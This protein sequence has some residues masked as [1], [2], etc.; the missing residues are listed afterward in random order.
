MKV[1]DYVT[2]KKYNHDIIFKIT[3]I[4]DG[5]AYLSGEMY[6]LAADASLDDLVLANKKD[7]NEEIEINLVQ[8]NNLIK[9]KI[10]HIDGDKTYLRKCMDFYKENLTPVIGCYLQ[11]DKMKDNIT[12]LLKKHCPDILIITGHDS[13]SFKRADDE[14]D[15]T[16]TLIILSMLLSKLDYINQIKMP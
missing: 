2:R 14:N 12:L 16:R 8:N 5:M 9:G 1:G 13:F 4:V 3:K 15:G 10:L 7:I 11:E 6:R